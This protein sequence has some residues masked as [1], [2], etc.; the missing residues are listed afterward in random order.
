M[1]LPTNNLSKNQLICCCCCF[2]FLFL[3]IGAGVYLMNKKKETFDVDEELRAPKTMIFFRANWCGHCQR[4]KPVW[5]EFVIES[6]SNP[7]IDMLELDIDLPDSKP[8]MEKHHVRGFPHLVLVDNVKNS[9]V[10][11]DRNRTKDDLL[12]FIK[13]NA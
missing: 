3:C 7:K 13:E 4:F 5:D 2:V 6:Q 12:S 1:K 11:F 9:E 8:Y 10:V